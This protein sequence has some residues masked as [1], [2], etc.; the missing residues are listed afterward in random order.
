M[1]PKRSPY[2]PTSFLIG[3]VCE[4]RSGFFDLG[5]TL[6][7]G[8]I[9][10]GGKLIIKDEED[11]TYRKK[12]DRNETSGL[13]TLNTVNFYS[14]IGI[15]I[16]PIFLIPFGITYDKGEATSFLS[17]TSG[18]NLGG[19]FS[20]GQQFIQASDRAVYDQLLEE[21][22]QDAKEKFIDPGKLKS[23]FL[24]GFYLSVQIGATSFKVTNYRYYGAPFASTTMY[25]VAYRFPLVKKR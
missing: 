4:A 15:D 19:H 14:Q 7:S 10:H 21:N 22:N 17:V 13:G 11:H 6:E 16:S 20:W 18:F 3:A 2:I 12:L 5:I 23:G 25:S 1:S 24:G 9:G 8:K